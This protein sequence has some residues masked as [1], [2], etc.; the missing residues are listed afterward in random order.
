[1]IP[2]F[3]TNQIRETDEWAIN[4]LKVPGLVLMEN[5]SLEIF[6]YIEPARE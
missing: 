2:L 6:R 1:M 4:E 5:A 3:S